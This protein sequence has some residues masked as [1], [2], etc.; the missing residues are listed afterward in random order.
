[1]IY[2]LNVAC[3]QVIFLSIFL[4]PILF[5]IEL[6][7]ILIFFSCY[8]FIIVMLLIIIQRWF[9]VISSTWSHS[10]SHCCPKEYYHALLL[11]CSQFQRLLQPNTTLGT[12][13]PRP[14]VIRRGSY[15]QWKSI[16]QLVVVTSGQVG[17]ISWPEM[18][19]VMEINASL[20][21]PKT[22]WYKCMLSERGS[23]FVRYGWRIDRT[24]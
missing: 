1:M 17:V 21:L 7:H 22:M 8:L 24:F 9:H 4:S 20:S 18:V 13:N 16:T 6:I 14:F 2:Y 15:G 5:I 11:N 12:P 3:N 19:W 23:E 10:T